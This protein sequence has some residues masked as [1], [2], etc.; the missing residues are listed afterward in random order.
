MR[1]SLPRYLNVADTA[2]VMGVTDD[3]VTDLIRSGQLAAV[4]VALH[5]GGRARWRIALSELEAFLASRRTSP[6]PSTPRRK[7]TG[8]FDRKYYT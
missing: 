8:A 1:E 7:R 2:G 3:K 6:K 5:A 4:N